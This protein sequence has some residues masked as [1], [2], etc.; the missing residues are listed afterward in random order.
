MRFETFDLAGG[1]RRISLHGRLDA[2]GTEAIE[3]AFTAA[4]SA[5][6]RH[7]LLDMRE[8]S[9][10]GSLGIRMILGSAR[11]LQRRGFNCMIV[12]AQQQP[13]DVFETTDLGALIPIV[14][15]EEEALKGLS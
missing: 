5:A 2:A 4:A 6:G 14:P 8:V 9:F 1:V 3:I 7:V 13:M 12:G 15:T 11:V 10:I